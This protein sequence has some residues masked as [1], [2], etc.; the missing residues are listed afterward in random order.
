MPPVLLSI[1]YWIDI[2][3]LQI[4]TASTSR[5]QRGTRRGVGVFIEVVDKQF[6]QGFS[7]FLPLFRRSVGITRIEDL[8]VNTRQL[9]RNRQVKH[10]QSEGFCVIQRTVED[11]VDN[12]AGIFNRDTFASAVPAGVNQIRLRTCRLHTFHQ[13]FCVLSRVQRQECRAEA[14]G[15]GGRRF[16]DA[17]LSTGQ[18]GGEAREEV[19]LGLIGSQTRNRRQHTKS[20]CGQEDNFSCV[21]R[22]GHRLNDVFDVIDRIRNASVLGF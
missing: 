19:I 17:T 8:R 5:Y 9:G 3:Q 21:A 14:S 20:V 12:G 18:F 11:G 6:R 7:F 4:I 10:R 13:H 22:F 1:R 15:E 16:G 2:L